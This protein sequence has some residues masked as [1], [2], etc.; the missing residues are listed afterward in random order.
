MGV[1]DVRGKE[2]LI[3]ALDPGPVQRDPKLLAAVAD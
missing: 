3:I 1:I 2:I